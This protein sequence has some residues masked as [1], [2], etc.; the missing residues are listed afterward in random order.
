MFIHIRRFILGAISIIMFF[1]PYSNLNAETA[2][3]EQAQKITETFLRMQN[4]RQ[5]QGIINIESGA[6]GISHSI[7]EIRE[8]HDEDGAILAYI[9]ELEPHGFIATSADTNIYPI[10]AYS[11][12]ASFPSDE[13]DNPLYLL[14][15]EDMKLRIK[16]ITEYGRSNAKENNN[17]WNSYTNGDITDSS[18][19]FQQWPQV[20]TTS[21]GGLIETTW[22]QQSPYNDFCPIDP[23]DS[24]RCVVGCTATA[25]AQVINYYRQCSI[26][27]DENDSYTTYNGIDIDNDSIRYDFPSFEQ[28]NG[29]L[30]AL[31]NKYASQTEPDDSDAAALSF[32]CGIATSMDYSSRGS[33]ASFYDSQQALLD[34]FYFYSADLVGSLSN[35][36]FLTLQENIINKIPAMFAIR[37]SDGF[38]GH[39]IICD[40]Y[41]TNGEYHLNFG[42]G[43]PY[44]E[45]ITDVWY[46]LPSELPSYL[47]IISLAMLNIQPAPA[48]IEIT[49]TPY[50]F[51]SSPGQESD[52]KTLS[53]KNNTTKQVLINSITSPDGFLVSQ[54]DDGYSNHIDSFYIQQPGQEISLNVKFC[55][56]KARGYYGI[57]T[58]DYSNG[59]TK[60]VILKGCSF[61]GGTF[62][63]SGRAGVSGT[64]TQA[65]S[66]Y[67][68]YSNITISNNETLLIEPGVKVLFAGPYSLIV[69][70]N[71][72]LIAEGNENQMIE[73]TALNTDLGWAGLRFINSGDD[74]KLSFCSITYSKKNSGLITEDDEEDLQETCGGAV[75][76][77]L[78][79]PV[80]TNCKITNNIG[81]LGGAIYCYYSNPE[82][83]NTVIANNSSIGG[84]PQCGGI[85][86]EQS[87]MPEIKNCTIVNN[88]PGGIFTNSGD[89]AIIINSIIWGNERYQI[90]TYVSSSDV[91]YCDVQG[92]YEGQGNIDID[93]NFFSPSPG[94]GTDYDG[95]SANWT[96]RSTSACINAGT[97][98]NLPPT[99]LS[100]SQR[101]YSD[102]IDIGAYE[103][104]SELP[105]ITTAASV[106]AGYVALSTSSTVNFDI[107]NTG[108]IDFK[109]ESLVIDDPNSAFFIITN[110]QDHLLEPGDSVRAVIGFAPSE[111]KDYIGTVYIN[112]TC[113]NAPL[114]QVSLHGVGV[115][116]TIIPGGE[117]SGT[118]VQPQSP[119]SITGDIYIPQGQ[120]LTIKPGVTIKFAG[121]FSLTSGKNSTLRAIGTQ[122]KSITFTANNTN[123]GWSG[124]RFIGSGDDDILEYCT[125]EYAKKSRTDAYDYLELIGGGILCCAEWG[126]SPDNPFIMPDVTFSSPTISHCLITNNHAL[127]GGGIA[128]VEYCEANI[129]H[130][131]II[132]NTAGTYGA[133]IYLWG[134]FS[135]LSNNIIAHNSG[136]ISGGISTE[137]GGPNIIN[138]TIVHNNPN[139][140]YLDIACGACFYVPVVNNIIWE[141]EIYMTDDVLYFEYDISYNN[142]QGSWTG[143]GN[144][145][146]DPCFADPLNRDYHLK[147][148][149]GRW[150]PVSQTWIQDNV[151]SPCIDAG[152]PG[153]FFGDEPSPKGGYINMGAYG[154]TAQASKSIATNQP[155]K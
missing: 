76:C 128:C 79:N 59:K 72:R 38:S 84:I 68:V 30:A 50:I 147:S 99:D 126:E 36:Y 102:I 121:H 150:D 15:K 106:D 46:R 25:L 100:G 77:Y 17:L 64:W 43:S 27:F 137:A 49:S 129:I 61:T 132:D 65:Q 45:E 136:S 116:G 32:A 9:A 153:S 69:G 83:S 87:S 95:L 120:I 152:D 55:P 131:R 52:A 41:N 2:G 35:E 140:L 124:I 113:S 16:A 149:A 89:G 56:D 23:V 82:I 115:S 88:S 118:W 44:P 145:D 54:T 4:A 110:V 80:I 155:V 39:I 123:E 107:T 1:P 20:N 33:G 91:T 111:E 40:G 98:V 109:V 3:V 60:N 94:A 96:L 139:A 7:S 42:W 101:I 90:Q 8:L 135:N 127:S 24:N 75:Y 19:T 26:S 12:K 146:L 48:S 53:I 10:V 74:D 92:G 104:Q 31:N 63:M 134:D 29:Y 62:I 112:S 22:N 67:I 37:S 142:I 125:I 97:L 93:P 85:F 70:E 11:S 86:T 51:Y 108:M 105:L 47:C 141:N 138:N 144:I 6:A 78:S 66:P 28:L 81:D 143:Q 154:G 71:E 58:I 122:Q 21:T 119:Y 148:Q 130:N 34:K 18:E 117:V 133:G 5:N 73:F 13:K 114:K 14:L 151:T 103:N 57:L